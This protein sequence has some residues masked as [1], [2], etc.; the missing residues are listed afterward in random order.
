MGVASNSVRRREAPGES[1][2]QDI[3]VGWGAISPAELRHCLMMPGPG[4]TCRR[5]LGR[6]LL[7]E[8]RVTEITLARALAESTACRPSICPRRR[9]TP[10]SRARFPNWWP[11]VPSSSRC[12]SRTLTLRI[13]AADPVDVVGLDDVRLHVLRKHKG[14]RVQVVVAPETSCDADWRPPGQ[15]ENAVE[16]LEAST[17]AAVTAVVEEASGSDEGGVLARPCIESPWRRRSAR[18]Q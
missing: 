12:R 2:T 16:A 11:N 8:E 14:V 3:L 9:S 5:R 13:A 4:T 1:Q 6:I 10:T 7:D 18:R 17:A 15:G